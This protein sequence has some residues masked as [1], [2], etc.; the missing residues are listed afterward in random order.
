[1]SRQGHRQIVTF[2][3]EFV[4]SVL[5]AKE[6]TKLSL[7]LLMPTLDDLTLSGCFYLE[8]TQ[9]LWNKLRGPLD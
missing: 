3:N 8:D 9:C 6:H 7:C 1:M 4:R 2:I 5:S